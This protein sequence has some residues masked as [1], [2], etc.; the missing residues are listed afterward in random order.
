MEEK[1]ETNASKEIFQ[2]TK[3]VKTLTDIQLK[4]RFKELSN[5]EKA[6]DANREWYLEAVVRLIQHQYYIEHDLDIPEIIDQNFIDFF[7]L[8]YNSGSA[9]NSAIFQQRSR[10]N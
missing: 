8:E 1:K 9:N 2:L 7:K 3:G 6:P 5:K 4:K 10:Y